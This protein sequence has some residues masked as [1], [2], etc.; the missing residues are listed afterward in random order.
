M[1]VKQADTE[2]ARQQD[3]QRQQDEQRQGNQSRQGERGRAGQQNAQGGQ[4]N[5]SRD[6]R[7]L[8]R[9]DAQA[10]LTPFA[11]SPFSLLQRFFTNDMAE[12]LGDG[13]A[14]RGLASRGGTGTDLTAWEPNVDVVQE[15]N[16]LVAR[17]DLP[18]LNPDEVTVEIS[19]DAITLSGE[20]QQEREEDQNGV[21]RIERTYGAFY[22]V[23]PL[24]DG[25]MTDRATATFRDGVL[26]IRMPAPPEQVSRGRRLEVSRGDKTGGT[27]GQPTSEAN[28][29]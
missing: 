7:G 3:Q 25:A 2:Q 4:Q 8:S 15:G 20:R 22:R 16:E 14:G 5:Q 9:R 29:S 12:V 24:P 27:S 18:G 1:A 21:Y 11:L 26:E 23:I 10:L 17:A 6:E 28:R 19:D 13:R